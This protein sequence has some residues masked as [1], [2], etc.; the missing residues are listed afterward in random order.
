MMKHLLAV[1]ALILSTNSWAVCEQPVDRPAKSPPA[2]PDGNTASRQDMYT[3]EDLTRAYVRTIE[4]YLDCYS[5]RY[6]KPHFSMQYNLLVGMAQNAADT[7]NGELRKFRTRET[8]TAS[9]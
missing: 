4:N 9:N 3:A 5:F 6:N 2:I 7:Y 1:S 8:A